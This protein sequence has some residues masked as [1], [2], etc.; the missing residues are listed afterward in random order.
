MGVTGTGGRGGQDGPAKSCAYGRESR[1]AGQCGRAE[2][3][4]AG[5]AVG[6]GSKWGLQ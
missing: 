5:G 3:R 2:W 4:E 1:R 6:R